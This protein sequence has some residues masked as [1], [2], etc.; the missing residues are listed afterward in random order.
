MTRRI[1]SGCALSILLA[2]AASADKIL[3]KDGRSYEGKL[4]RESATEITLAVVVLGKTVE[5]TVPLDQIEKFERSTS[6]LEQYEARAAR[7]DRKDPDALT[8]LAAWCRDQKLPRQAASHLLEALDLKPDHAKASKAIQD[9]GYVRKG[10][11][12]VPKSAPEQK[13]T[14]GTGSQESPAAG[15][16]LLAELEKAQR[17][18]TASDARLKKLESELAAAEKKL[19]EARTPQESETV[20]QE[21]ER[22]VGDLERA[23]KDCESRLRTLEKLEGT[24][25][26]DSASPANPLPQPPSNQQS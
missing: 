11:A 5:M 13:A 15:N 19:A 3:L 6:L 16:P 7:V 18:V 1:A 12:W 23:L 10:K 9:L 20:R 14:T 2:L 26:Q 25:Q 8:E 22:I 24:Q 17:E 4:V 21:I